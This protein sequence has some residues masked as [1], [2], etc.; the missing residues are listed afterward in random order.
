METDA[1]KV[2][3]YVSGKIAWTLDTLFGMKMGDWTFIR[4]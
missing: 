3:A 2:R 4:N 1:D